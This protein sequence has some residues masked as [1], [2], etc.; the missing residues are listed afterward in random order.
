MQSSKYQRTAARTLAAAII[1]LGAV[2]LTRGDGAGPVQFNSKLRL[3][4]WAV[5][6]IGG[7]QRPVGDTPSPT[8]LNIP[9]CLVW[10]VRPNG[11]SVQEVAQEIQAQSIPGLDISWMNLS[12]ADFQHLSDAKGLQFLC[13]VATRLNDAR[14]ENLKNMTSLQ[15]LRI[16]HN[17]DVTGAGL[18]KIKGLTALKWLDLRGTLVDDTAVDALKQFKALKLLIFGETRI[19]TNPADVAALKAALPACDIHHD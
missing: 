19:K 13:L 5:M 6:Q 2:G 9:A 8:P 15:Y 11:V 3:H 18:Q 4:V 14:V 12:D 10:G 16:D 1:L 7:E 17:T